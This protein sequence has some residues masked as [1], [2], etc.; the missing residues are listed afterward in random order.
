[1]HTHVS[2]VIWLHLKD[3]YEDV[4]PY[5]DQSSEKSMLWD[6]WLTNFRIVLKIS[7]ATGRCECFLIYQH[8][9]KKMSIGVLTFPGCTVLLKLC[10]CVLEELNLIRLYC[11]N[12]I[13]LL[14]YGTTRHFIALCGS[15][16]EL[17]NNV[18]L[19]ITFDSHKQSGDPDV[20]QKHRVCRH[21]RGCSWPDLQ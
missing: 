4:L 21:K 2:V 9:V 10:K 1:M 16:F 19:K 12:P 14:L 8:K 17:E 13:A 15:C 7:I 20:C 6:D 5:T 3:I 11:Y 18:E